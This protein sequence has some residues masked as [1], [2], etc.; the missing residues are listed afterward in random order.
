MVLRL[1]NA[2]QMPREAT[3]AAMHAAGFAN[4]Y[5]RRCANDA[6]LEP[7]RKAVAHMLSAHEPY[8]AVAIDRAWT[9]VAANAPAVRLFSLVGAAGAANMIDALLAAAEGEAIENWEE[10]AVLS[11]SRLR[12]EIIATGGDRVLEQYSEKIAAHPRM[13]RF[14]TSQVDFSQAVIPTIFSVGG[15]RL[16]LF[17]TIA[18]FGTVQDVA[19]ADLRIE[20]MFPADDASER[21]L[22]SGASLADAPA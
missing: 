17:S 19:A 1:A 22:R 18:Q 15:V 20:M 8:P 13:K 10:T 12:A 6:A 2:L 9:I 21:W 14:D 7:V 3:N 4:A 16:S 11:L 5:S